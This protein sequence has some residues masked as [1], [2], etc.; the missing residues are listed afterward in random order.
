MAAAG[1]YLVSRRAW[2]S[3]NVRFTRRLPP[4]F[5]IGVERKVSVA[6]EKD[7]GEN[8][9]CELYDHVE[10]SV[11]AV[12]L[13][14]TLVLPKGKRV[15][16]TY[17]LTPTRRGALVFAAAEVRVRSR[18]GLCELGVRLGPTEVRRVYPD[19]AAIARSAWLAG[20]RRLQEIGIKTYQLRGEGTDFKQLAEYRVGDAVRHIDWKATLRVNRPIVLLPDPDSPVNQITA[21]SICFLPNFSRSQTRS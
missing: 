1:D 12:G 6:L 8:W 3:G 21:G 19:F 15:E 18:G 11:T 13:P 2:R 17:S 5:A 20:D 14:Q 16:G 4:A 9:N 7:G 10:S